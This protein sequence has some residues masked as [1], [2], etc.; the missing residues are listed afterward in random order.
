MKLVYSLGRR[1]GNL[2]K[3]Y[4]Q[5]LMLEAVTVT[6]KLNHLQQAATSGP[7][8]NEFSPCQTL[9]H[10]FAASSVLGGLTV[11]QL[12]MQK[13][14]LFKKDVTSLGCIHTW[15]QLIYVSSF[16]TRHAFQLLTLSGPQLS[17][18]V[19]SVFL[20]LTSFMGIRSWNSFAKERVLNGTLLC[21]K[22]MSPCCQQRITVM[23]CH[24]ITLQPS[25]NVWEKDKFAEVTVQ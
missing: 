19:I 16:L 18:T 23:S 12:Y 7:P 11:I 20:A 10:N 15:S 9:V 1:K 4:S 13:R 2:Q 24:V 3:D 14:N 22:Q 6:R 5:L 25:C 21:P 8:R 17:R